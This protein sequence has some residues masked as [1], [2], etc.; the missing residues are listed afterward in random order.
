MVTGDKN[1]IIR[2]LDKV[3]SSKACE[4]LSKHDCFG[5]QNTIMLESDEASVYNYHE[6][7]LIVDRYEREDVWPTEVSKIRDQFEIL[8]TI[9]EN[10][11]DILDRCEGD[12]QKFLKENCL[13][14]DVEAV[15]G[16]IHL[17]EYLRKAK[18]IDPV[19]FNFDVPAQDKENKAESTIEKVLVNKNDKSEVSELNEKMDKLEIE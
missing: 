1:G 16:Q 19:G 3:W 4:D 13:D 5:P 17:S 14:H 7:S 9:K 10:L 18:K 8:R 2:D 15:D 11:F 12:V 6:N